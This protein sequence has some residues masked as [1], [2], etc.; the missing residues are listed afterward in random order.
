MVPKTGHTVN[1]EEP[2]TFNALVADF[3]ATVE[4][5]AWHERDRRSQRQSLTG[6]N[7]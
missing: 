2:A 4:N 5:G 6:M 7:G 3:F 1:L